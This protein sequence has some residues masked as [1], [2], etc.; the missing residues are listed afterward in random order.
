MSSPVSIFLRELRLR[1]GLTQLRLAQ[2]LGYEQGYVSAIELGLKNPST[3]YLD[4]LT[5]ALKVSE[6]EQVKL[7]LVVN[8][9][10]R[11]FTLSPEVST[12]TFLFCSDL[13]EKIERLHPVLLDSL[14]DLLKYD[15]LLTERPPE[16]PTRIRRQKMTEAPCKSE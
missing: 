14:H 12:K 10:K 7:A 6:K 13:W 5:A 8:Q 9:S 2:E 16:Q 15:D 3:E 11:H 4:K 1:A